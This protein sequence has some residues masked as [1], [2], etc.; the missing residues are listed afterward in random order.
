MNKADYHRLE[1]GDRVIAVR[2]IT[3]DGGRPNKRAKKPGD[4][5]CISATKGDTGVVESIHDDRDDGGWRQTYVRWTRTGFACMVFPPDI[6]LNHTPP[7][8]ACKVAKSTWMKGFVHLV[9]DGEGLVSLWDSKIANVVSYLKL[10]LTKQQQRLIEET[11]RKN[12]PT[13]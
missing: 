2:T 3:D 1:E 13:I 8:K 11:M 9:V 6:K 12:G 10:P 7:P 4:P 5:G